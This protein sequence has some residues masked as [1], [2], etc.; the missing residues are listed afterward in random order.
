MVTV[1][2]AQIKKLVSLANRSAKMAIVHERASHAFYTEYEN[3]FG[4]R[5]DV[6]KNGFE[7]PIVD[8][9][10]YGNSMVDDVELIKALSDYFEDAG[11]TVLFE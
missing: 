11:Q 9:V 6:S 10:E 2:R 4:T 3:I 7:D 5:F 1:T 8:V